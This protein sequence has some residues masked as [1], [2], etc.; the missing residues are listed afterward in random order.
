MTY[1]STPSSSQTF[2]IHPLTFLSVPHS[3]R[4]PRLGRHPMA[5]LPKLRTLVPA[6]DTEPAH[7]L[8]LGVLSPDNGFLRS[9]IML[10]MELEDWTLRESFT[11][12]KR[13]RTNG[14]CPCTENILHLRSIV[15]AWLE[16][17][18]RVAH[19]SPVPVFGQELPGSRKAWAEK[20]AQKLML[21]YLE[22]TSAFFVR[23]SLN[24]LPPVPA[25]LPRGSASNPTHPFCPQFPGPLLVP[26]KATINPVT[27]FDGLWVMSE[28][29]SG[30]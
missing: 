27:D 9:L 2:P 10:I 17:R 26:D 18:T 22:N 6:H 28:D 13:Q 4:I 11:H 3:H 5:T 12:L 7:Q 29:S 14:R 30:S 24:P 8:W 1:I 20:E 25:A 16:S 23:T 19:N 21:W 15:E